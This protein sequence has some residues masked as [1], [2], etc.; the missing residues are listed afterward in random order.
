VA[1]NWLRSLFRRR[2]RR[3]LTGRYMGAATIYPHSSQPPLMVGARPA[4]RLHVGDAVEF[5]V[6]ERTGLANKVRVY[7]RYER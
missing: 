5:T 6:S 7:R 4:R 3:Y 2:P 1:L